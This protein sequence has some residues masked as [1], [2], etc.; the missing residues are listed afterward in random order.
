MTVSI[1]YHLKL[2]QP[3]GLQQALVQFFGTAAVFPAVCENPVRPCRAA[4]LPEAAPGVPGQGALRHLRA[5]AVQRGSRRAGLARGC[6]AAADPRRREAADGPPSEAAPGVLPPTGASLACFSSSLLRNLWPAAFGA[7][8]AITCVA[9]LPLCFCCL[10]V[11]QLYRWVSRAAARS[12][13]AGLRKTRLQPV[14]Q[15]HLLPDIQRQPSAGRHRGPQ[16][17]GHGAGTDDDG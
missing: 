13:L 11:W 14:V 12:A 3:A 15:R 2:V 5:A 4:L 1:S 8:S 7:V 6:C 17:A 16:V 10:V 9:A